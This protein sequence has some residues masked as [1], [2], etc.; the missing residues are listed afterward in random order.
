MLFQISE[1]KQKYPDLYTF[2]FAETSE[3]LFHLGWNLA[4]GYNLELKDKG[5][6]HLPILNITAAISTP[7]HFQ[8][9]IDI[10]HKKSHQTETEQELVSSFKAAVRFDNIIM[11]AYFL[12]SYPSISN[13]SKLL[14]T[15]IEVAKKYKLD[16]SYQLLITKI[17]SP[18]GMKTNEKLES[19]VKITPPTLPV[20]SSIKL[21]PSNT[22]KRVSWDMSAS[23]ETRL[24]Y[25][26][27][28]H[29]IVLPGLIENVPDDGNCFFHAFSRQLKRLNLKDLSHIDLR[30][31]GI[32]YIENNR[33]EFDQ[34]FC[35]EDNLGSIS[36]S[37]DEYLVRMSNSGTIDTPGAWADGPVI[38]AL[39]RKYNIHIYVSELKESGQYFPQH[40]NEDE[41]DESKPIVAL[42]LYQLHY[43]IL[44]LDKRTHTNAANLDF[45]IPSDKSPAQLIE[46]GA[47]MVNTSEK[48]EFIAATMHSLF[49]NTKI[50][51]D[52][53]LAD[54][55]HKAVQINSSVPFFEDPFINFDNII[56]QAKQN[57]KVS[58]K[59]E[60]SV[61]RATLLQVA[62][63]SIWKAS[64]YS[65]RGFSLLKEIGDLYVKALDAAKNKFNL[66]ESIKIAQLADHLLVKYEEVIDSKNEYS[67]TYT[68]LYESGW[69]V[70]STTLLLATEHLG[71]IVPTA[72]IASGSQTSESFFKNTS[73]KKSLTQSS[74][75]SEF[76]K[77]LDSLADQKIQPVRKKQTSQEQ[78]TIKQHKW[79]S[80][81]KEEQGFL[82][83][84]VWTSLDEAYMYA[85]ANRNQ[86][87][88]MEKLTSTP[89]LKKL[90]SNH[91]DIFK[92]ADERVVH[93]APMLIQLKIT[94][95]E[96]VASE[97]NVRYFL[98]DDSSKTMINDC[99]ILLLLKKLNGY[100]VRIMDPNT[101]TRIKR[102]TELLI[103]GKINIE[104]AHE[105][106]Q[107]SAARRAFNSL[108]SDDIESLKPIDWAKVTGVPFVRFPEDMTVEDI[109][110]LPNDWSF[111]SI[112]TGVSKLSY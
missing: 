32:D 85:M 26:M 93:I 79:D 91:V 75:S 7:A 42:V 101:T 46:L 65:S 24:E 44:N 40:Y 20:R 39:A 69:N 61:A 53:L 67:K 108:T 64:R 63:C 36:E 4:T 99:I 109:L 45:S 89:Q 50:D 11:V 58:N 66:E 90:A 12:E 100:Q 105:L 10:K 97:E 38:M 17:R 3:N 102:L 5:D 95:D 1:I 8:I 9:L 52:S 37:L 84:G 87:I 110:A 48:L 83:A 23:T 15:T 107:N 27:K 30:L 68:E 88:P 81:T 55:M 21:N 112:E 103:M 94:E 35:K 31:E 92:T 77:G 60:V 41:K 22:H 74:S 78:Q 104:T 54:V 2:L 59:K 16:Q 62:A 18:E 73:T 28:E 71:K 80:L 70:T 51:Y 111:E 6:S 14:E 82:E 25:F 98:N 106:A 13:N 47:H 19:V 49:D 96:W 76:T 43:Y 72:T 56:E 86:E 34:Y 33:D 57:L 29:H